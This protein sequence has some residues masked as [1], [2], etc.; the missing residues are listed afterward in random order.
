MMILISTAHKIL[1]VRVLITPETILPGKKLGID[2]VTGMKKICSSQGSA[3]D[4]SLAT[5][6]NRLDPNG[7]PQLLNK[8][9]R[10]SVIGFISSIKFCY[11][12]VHFKLRPEIQNFFLELSPKN[13]DSLS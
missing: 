10:K 13:L 2:L 4:P 6:T 11:Y 12:E 8:I 7:F 9:F 3:V 1:Y 5:L